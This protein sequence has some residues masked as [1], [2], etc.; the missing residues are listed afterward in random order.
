MN[1]ER[2]LSTRW[3]CLCCAV[4]KPPR[5]HTVS[6]LKNQALCEAQENPLRLQENNRFKKY[7]YLFKGCPSNI[8]S[9][10]FGSSGFKSLYYQFPV[11]WIVYNRIF[12][13]FVWE[14]LCK[15]SANAPPTAHALYL[16]K[17]FMAQPH[18]VASCV[19][20]LIYTRPKLAPFYFG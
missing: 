11:E 5:C 4:D 3:C 1:F 7:M 12:N 2:S 18:S 15:R 19:L 6:G 20:S 10:L 9:F 16:S 17:V 13:M 8:D 14:V